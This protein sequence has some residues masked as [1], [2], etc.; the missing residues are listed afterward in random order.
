MNDREA[1]KTMYRLDS[2]CISQ[3]ATDKI[4]LQRYGLTASGG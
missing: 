2:L 4:T 1:D 3:I